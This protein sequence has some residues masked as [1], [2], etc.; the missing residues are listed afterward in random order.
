MGSE[1]V[2]DSLPRKGIGSIEASSPLSLSEQFYEHLPYY[3]AIGMTYDQFW[4]E[5]CTLVKYYRKAHQIKQKQ[6]N[7][8]LWL[9]GLYFYD[10][11]C[12]VSPILHAF[13]KKGT[14]PKPY[15]TEP[16]PTTDKEVAGRKERQRILHIEKMKAKMAAWAAKTNTQMAIITQ[17]G[18]VEQD[19]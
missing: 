2:S 4:N 13:A 10:A 12:D 5:D 17:K 8:E 7:Q 14:K 1:L 11:L 9:Q 3:L 16:Y 6:R 19:G 18:E 15:P